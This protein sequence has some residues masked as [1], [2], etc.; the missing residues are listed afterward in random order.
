MKQCKDCEP[1][2]KRPTPYPGPRCATHHR[3]FKRKQKA[4]NHDR[5]VQKTYGLAPGEYAEMY[6]RQGGRCAICRRA[7][8][9]VKR[10]AVDHSHRTGAVRGLLCGPCNQLLGH[11]RDSP[12]SLRRAAEYLEETVHNDIEIHTVTRVDLPASSLADW[13]TENSV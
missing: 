5:S 2:S 4:A 9:K 8:G 6:E 1:G 10:L 7:T 12:S 3:A 13:L 11:F